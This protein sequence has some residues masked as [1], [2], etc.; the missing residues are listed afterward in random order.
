MMAT[1]EE[2]EKALVPV[3]YRD[4]C[5]HHFIKWQSCLRKELIHTRC[6]PQESKWEECE[7]HEHR[8]L[9]RKRDMERV[10]EFEK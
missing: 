4:Y 8:R 6:H 3:E 7:Y 2:M 9:W 10:A 5:A 1:N